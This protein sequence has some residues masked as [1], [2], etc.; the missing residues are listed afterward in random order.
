MRIAAILPL[1]EIILLYSECFTCDA[2]VTENGSELNFLNFFM[3]SV[4]TLHIYEDFKQN[5]CM[6]IS[7]LCG[8]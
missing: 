4:F 6:C 5:Y 2:Q 7:V 1:S 3:L 8:W